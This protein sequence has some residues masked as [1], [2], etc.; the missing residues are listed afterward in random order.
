MRTTAPRA[1]QTENFVRLTCETTVADAAWPW[2]SAGVGERW[3]KAPVKWISSNTARCQCSLHNI[4]AI[5]RKVPGRRSARET[6]VTP[7]RNLWSRRIGKPKRNA[8]SGICTASHSSETS[9]CFSPRAVMITSLRCQSRRPTPSVR[10]VPALQRLELAGDP[11][12]V[13]ILT[14]NP[15]L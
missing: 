15:S 7:V 13:R 11:R 2:D 8:L 12:G 1:W 9:R 6:V 5:R 4:G 10:G 3:A 14:C